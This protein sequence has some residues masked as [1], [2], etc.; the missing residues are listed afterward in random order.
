MMKLRYLAAAL[1]AMAAS[2]AASAQTG[3]T[4]VTLYG[5][6]DAY[7]QSARG[8]ETLHRLQSGGLSGSR[9]GIRGSEDLGGGLRGIFT[10]ESGINLDDGTSGQGAFWGRQ[11]FVGLDSRFGTLT[12]G[13][14]YGSIY[15]LTSEFSQF[16]NGPIGASTA[17]IGGFGGYE[18][19]R[20]NGTDG[21]ATGNGGPARINNSVKYESPSLA[22]FRAGAMVGLGEVAGG[23]SG[24]RV[25][26]VYARY[27]NG[28]LDLMLSF[29]DDKVEASGL[30]VR[31]ISAAGAYRIGSYRLN[32]GVLD[33]DDRVTTAAQGQGWWVGGDYRHGRS[34]YKLQYLVSEAKGADAGKTQALGIGYQFDLTKRTSLYSTLTRF[35]NEGATYA[36]RWASTMPQSLTTASDRHVTEL[37]AGIRHVF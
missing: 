12:L 23:T 29:V 15:T 8:A 14:Q 5:I 9:F 31:T 22:G 36:N 21:T 19:V 37:V 32:A 17:I 26:D 13:R 6:V 30:E 10:L 18:P 24:T 3:S 34:Q 33:V 2:G 27:G 28:P 16:T 7:V 20:G 4:N 25:A 11:A 35:H 1:A